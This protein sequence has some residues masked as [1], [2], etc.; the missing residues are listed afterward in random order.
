MAP[1]LEYRTP[2]WTQHLL[3]NAPLK[4]CMFQLQISLLFTVKFLATPLGNVI[5]SFNL[6]DDWNL[7]FHFYC[8]ETRGHIIK[9]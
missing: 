1:T 9:A 5:I 2:F 8:I 6:N 7:W 4:Y 3:H